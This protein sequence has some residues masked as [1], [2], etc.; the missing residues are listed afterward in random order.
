[1]RNAHCSGVRKS[2]TSN[3][4]I[5]TI[6]E[7]HT[8]LSHTFS[9]EKDSICNRIGCRILLCGSDVPLLT[10]LFCW[11]SIRGEPQSNVQGAVRWQDR[12]VCTLYLWYKRGCPILGEYKPKMLNRHGLF[13]NWK[14]SWFRHG[15]VRS[16]FYD[17]RGI[18]ETRM[19]HVVYGGASKM[20]WVFLPIPLWINWSF[21]NVGFL[22][23]LCDLQTPCREKGR[24]PCTV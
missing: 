10:R 23:Q 12:F 19:P 17:W 9:D 24:S 5:K 22:L 1:M 14:T 3:K 7:N 21:Q 11:F 15:K 2:A 6:W 8:K 16:Q 18:V 20:T 13:R 4:N